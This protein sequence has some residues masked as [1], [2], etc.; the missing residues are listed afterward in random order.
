MLTSWVT[1]DWLIQ[2][3]VVDL[4]APW[5]DLLW[6]G[7]I[8]IKLSWNW[9]DVALLLFALPRKHPYLNQTHCF[10]Q[11]KHVRG[12]LFPAVCYM[13][14]GETADNFLTRVFWD[15]PP[16]PVLCENTQKNNCLTKKVRCDGI[17]PNVFKN[18]WQWF[19]QDVVCHCEV[20]GNPTGYTGV[21]DSAV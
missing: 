6:F 18:T 3:K 11:W 20:E 10:Q 7:T 4:K 19:V 15:S 8:Q 14:E 16:P 17:L 2:S 5:D 1:K 13:W 12:V 9:P 21:W